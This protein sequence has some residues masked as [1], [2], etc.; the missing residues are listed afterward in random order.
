MT[1]Q[2]LDPVD[3]F[4]KKKKHDALTPHLIKERPV[5]NLEHQAQAPL[6]NRVM[7]HILRLGGQEFDIIM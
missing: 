2:A 4:L 1:N 7:T 5:S 6:E 3:I